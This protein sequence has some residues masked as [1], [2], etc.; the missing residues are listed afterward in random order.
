MTVSPCLQTDECQE[1]VAE[2]KKRFPESRAVSELVVLLATKEQSPAAAIE[3]LQGDASVGGRLGLAHMLVAQGQLGKAAKC[4]A[5]IDEIAHTP[6]TVA[7][8]VSLYEAVGDAASAQ[9]AL[10]RALAFH[11]AR[12]FASDHAMKLREGDCAHKIQKRQYAAAAEA[13]LDLLEGENAAALA[14]ELRLRSLAS[15]VVA[16]YVLELVELV[17]RVARG[18]DCWFLQVVLRRQGGGDALPDAPRGPRERHGA[19]RAGASGAAL[20]QA[21]VQARGRWRQEERVRR[22]ACA[23]W[24]VPRDSRL[25]AR[26]LSLVRRKRAAK[27]P[28]MVARKRAKRRESHLAKLRAR[29]DFNASIGLLPPDPERWIPKKQRSHGKR[30]RRGRNRFVGAQGAGMATDKD[31]LKLD[32]A[33]RAATK[34]AAPEKPAAVVVSDSSAVLRKA[35]KKKRR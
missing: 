29:P 17:D 4:L 33:A 3:Q 25:V 6:G 26:S 24:S 10:D 19:E 28:E 30:G 31:A 27:S 14:P 11:K 20:E 8:L 2:L 16:L 22:A 32:A 18:A 1:Q 5:S 34:A 35:K 23:A 21:A 7:T 15:L 13:Y 9:A 12:D